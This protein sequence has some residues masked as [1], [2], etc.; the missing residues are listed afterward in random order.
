MAMTGR[1]NGRPPL[2]AAR[3][4]RHGRGV[5]AGRPFR[6]GEVLE[7]SPMISL[8]APD[9]R[10]LERTPLRQYLYERGHGAV[11]AL[12]L[13]S[14]LNHARDP[15]ARCELLLDEGLLVVKARRAIQP[16]EE[17]TIRYC[18]DDEL[19]FEPRDSKG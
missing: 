18:A 11:L 19:W 6:R 15:N 4:S 2:Y 3:S 9:R 7:R 12:G 1:S 5:F 10:A 8:S 16:G 14:L 13:G 17:V